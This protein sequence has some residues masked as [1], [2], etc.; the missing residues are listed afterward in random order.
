MSGV[1]K[2]LAMTGMAAEAIGEATSRILGE[3]YVKF[4]KIS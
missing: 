3:I 4:N 1:A 2:L